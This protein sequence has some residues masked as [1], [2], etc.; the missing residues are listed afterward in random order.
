MRGLIFFIVLGAFFLGCG[1]KPKEASKEGVEDLLLSAENKV[2]SFSLAGYE[3]NGKKKWEVEG[4]SADIMPELVNLTDVVAK[5]YGEEINVTLVA[6]KGV[7]NRVS[8]DVH[9]ESDVKLISTDGTEMTTETLDWKNSEGKIYTDKPV[10]VTREDVETLSTGAEGSP[11]LKQIEFK[12]DVKITTAKPKTVITCEG[13]MEFDY[14]KNYAEFNNKV[15]VE[16]ERGQ[17]HCDKATAYYDPKSHQVTKIVASGNVKIVRGGS[18]TLSDEAVYLAQE[19]KIILTGSPK[20]TIY[21]E[22]ADSAKT[23]F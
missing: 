14:G 21:P 7:F 9:L 2:M 17:I 8:N 3:N 5:A 6:D 11:N 16:D 18:W 22:D 1:E 19:E 12:R 20:I 15:K 13:P 10:K 23:G 4:K